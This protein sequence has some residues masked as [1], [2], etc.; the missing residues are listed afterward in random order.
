[1]GLQRS[2]VTS[3]G[4]D[5]QKTTIMVKS[6]DIAA[7]AVTANNNN[8][9]LTHINPAQSKQTRRYEV[10]FMYYS[11]QVRYWLHLINYCLFSSKKI[12]SI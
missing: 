1:M 9:I 7:A 12:S 10:L 2:T 11:S 3:T 5:A 8:I 4:Y 6:E